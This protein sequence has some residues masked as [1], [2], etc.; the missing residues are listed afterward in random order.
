MSRHRFDPFSFLFGAAFI[1]VAVGSLSGTRLGKFRPE[2]FW[3]ISV[4]A[5]GVALVVWA[6]IAIARRDRPAVAAYTAGSSTSEPGEQAT[7]I[8][9]SDGEPAD[10]DASDEHPTL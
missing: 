6:I 9:T 10:E 4:V 7:A 2:A 5:T 8:G 3:S 1:I